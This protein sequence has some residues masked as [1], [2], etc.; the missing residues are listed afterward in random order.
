MS[1]D[2]TLCVTVTIEATTDW[3]PNYFIEND[4]NKEAD[5][6]FKPKTIAGVSRGYME[7]VTGREHAAINALTDA[8]AAAGL[9]AEGFES[10]EEV[11]TA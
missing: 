5:A 8:L 4:F 2:K 11:A 9:D 1:T 7:V 3:E 10:F 6:A